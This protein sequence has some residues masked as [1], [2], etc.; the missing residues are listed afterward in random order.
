MR[1][2]VG[3]TVMSRFFCSFAIGFI[4]LIQQS[5]LIRIFNGYGMHKSDEHESVSTLFFYIA[6]ADFPGT[7]QRSGV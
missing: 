4:R 6:F 5:G 7:L 1:F 2:E 3:V